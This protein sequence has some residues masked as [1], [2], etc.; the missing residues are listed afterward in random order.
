MRSCLHTHTH[1]HA[2]Q[3]TQASTHKHVHV[4]ILRTYANTD[5]HTIG[6]MI[7]SEQ[8]VPKTEYRWS[9]DVQTSTS[10]VLQTSLVESGPNLTCRLG[11]RMKQ[12]KKSA[13]KPRGVLGE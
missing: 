9:K 8:N 3:Q 13:K 1:T 2:H 10:L 7:E 4:H 11:K 6:Y 12:Q 5:T